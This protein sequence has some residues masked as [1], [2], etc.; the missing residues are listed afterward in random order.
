[1]IFS[2]ECNRTDCPFN[3]VGVEVDAAIVQEARQ[4]VPARERVADCFGDRAAAWYKRKLLFEPDPHCLDDGLGA[5]AA[6]CEPV[7][8]R[9]TANVGF[10]S[11]KFGDLVQRLRRDRRIGCLRDLVARRTCAVYGSNMPQEQRL[12]SRRVARSRHI[13]RHAGRL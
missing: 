11:I 4:T 13:R 2:A 1:M 9:L 5:I 7:R 6:S 8:R 10:N 12:L 3:W